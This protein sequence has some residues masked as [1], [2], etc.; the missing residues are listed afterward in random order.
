MLTNQEG[1]V[2]SLCYTAA[3]WPETFNNEAA[4][5]RVP[6]R[7]PQLS[8]GRYEGFAAHGLVSTVH[9]LQSFSPLWPTGF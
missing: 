3:L 9:P 7:N 1:K 6:G 2:G 8:I 4:G 5:G